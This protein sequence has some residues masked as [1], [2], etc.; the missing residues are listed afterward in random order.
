[1]LNG[2]TL[3][4]KTPKLL[5]ANDIVLIATTIELRFTWQPDDVKIEVE[6][7]KPPPSKT[8]TKEIKATS[9]LDTS[10]SN[11]FAKSKRQTSNLGTGLQPGSL[12]DHV[13]VTYAREEWEAFVAPLTIIMQ[14]AGLKVW[15]DQYLAQGGDD[16]MLAVEQALSEC[17]MLVVVVSPEAMASR[18]VRLA[19]RYFYN[20]EKPVIPLIYAGVEDLP[21]E[22]KNFKT[23]RYNSHDRKKTFDELIAEVKS[24]DKK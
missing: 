15:V 17:K 9:Q 1:M 22:M 4:P 19:Y 2:V 21:P 14:D 3:P 10:E 24:R 7:P 18:Y 16:W 6:A 11:F 12:V 5:H 20:R 13:F 8:S 23:V